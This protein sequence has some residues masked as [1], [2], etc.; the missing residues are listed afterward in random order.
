MKKIIFCLIAVVGT[1]YSC[2]P[3]CDNI[4]AGGIVKESELQLDV[5]VS[6]YRAGRL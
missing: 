4:S 6:H 3:V 2:N 5:H 1:L